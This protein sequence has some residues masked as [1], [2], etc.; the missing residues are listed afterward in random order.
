MSYK[1]GILRAAMTDKFTPLQGT[2]FVLGTGVTAVST[3][4]GHIPRQPEE[5][6]EQWLKKNVREYP[7]TLELPDDF[8]AYIA[9]ILTYWATAEWIQQGTLSRLLQMERKELRVVLGAPRV[10]NAA[11]KITELV[12]SLDIAVTVNMVELTT[13]LRECESA[14]NLLG[15]GVWLIDPVTNELCVENPSGEW[16][17]SRE[18]AI[19]RRKYPQAFHPT[20]P[21]FEQTLS[22]IKASIRSLQKLDLEIE[23]ALVA[24]PQKSG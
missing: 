23:A 6:F 19:S 24:S 12:K 10:S 4:D 16:I 17:E 1:L 20:V 7:V 18:Q 13:K 9:K 21:W 22:D 8:L 3:G 14:R 15:H 5:T 2:S 11:S